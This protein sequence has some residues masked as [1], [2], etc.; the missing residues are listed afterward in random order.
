LLLLLLLL[1]WW[2]WWCL[3]AGICYKAGKQPPLAHR[4]VAACSPP[5]HLYPPPGTLL[6]FLQLEAPLCSILLLI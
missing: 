1:W 6:T 2:W 4:L 3:R 5:E